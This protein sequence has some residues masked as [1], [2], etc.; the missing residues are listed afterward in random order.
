MG[1]STIAFTLDGN[2]TQADV[3]QAFRDRQADDRD[4]NGHQDG[5]SGDFQTVNSVK[6]SGREFN[7]WDEAYDYCHDKA[8]KWD[9]VVAVKVVNATENQWLVAGWGAE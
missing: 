6:F 5:Y 7:N 9:Y 8:E 3:K 2:K 4:C 1:A